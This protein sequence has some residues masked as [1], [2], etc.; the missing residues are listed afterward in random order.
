MSSGASFTFLVGGMSFVTSVKICTMIIEVS[1]EQ[2]RSP[3]E[4]Y[5][6]TMYIIY[7]CIQSAAAA[8]AN[9]LWCYTAIVAA[10]AGLLLP[11]NVRRRV[12]HS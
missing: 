7:F 9:A 11:D 6:R 12:S 3:S 4:I 10:A 5:I 8:T 2:S 1:F